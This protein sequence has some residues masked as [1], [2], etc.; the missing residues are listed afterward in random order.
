MT[1]FRSHENHDIQTMT[2]E[3]NSSRRDWR[4]M[5]AVPIVIKQVFAKF[6]LTSY[7]P[8]ALPTRSPTHRDEHTLYTWTTTEGSATHNISFNPTCLKWQTYL[9]FQ[10]IAF[11]TR[12]SNNHASP[13]G[14]LPFLLPAD[15]QNPVASSKLE[16]WSHTN[17]TSKSS[18][19]QTPRQDVY[20]SL[21]DHAV[22]RAWLYLLYLD[23]D[24]FDNV[25]RRLY[26]TPSSSNTFVALA[27]SHQLRNAANQELL[28]ITPVVKAE[29]IL[30]EA[31][32]AFSALS[33]LL[34]GDTW[35]FGQE[36]PG[37]FDASVFAYTHLLLHEEMGWR[38][39]PL[40][41]QLATFQNL[42]MHRERILSGYYER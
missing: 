2:Q 25:A 19:I 3:S 42:V 9:L 40:A 30:K 32:D 14:S 20:A 5:F 34:G 24:N 35:F 27:I 31:V 38:N 22:R 1:N 6:P 39:N 28:K 4:D 17:S 8:N 41:E 11:R 23:P 15:S 16:A 12:S 7:T 36:K 13:S 10:G 33:T 37:L 29:D 18:D 21:L 26:V